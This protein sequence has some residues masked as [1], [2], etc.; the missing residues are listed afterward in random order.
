MTKDD[1][2]DRLLARARDGE[3]AATTAVIEG[4]RPRITRL[5]RHYASRSREEA[6]DLEQEAWVAILESIPQLRLEVGDPRQYLLR[7]G[8]WR[9]LN[10]IN[11]QAARRHEELTDDFD[12]PAPS[13]TSADAHAGHLLE[14][15]FERLTDRQ[16]V[17]LRALLAGHT[18]AETARLLEC[19]T[20]NIAWHMRKIRQVYRALTGQPVERRT[21]A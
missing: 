17:I 8:R 1:P 12:E 5:A 11:E 20:A 3:G 16:A 15:I 9:M 10:F 6:A 13:R 21:G 7:R 4:L 14:R 18:W 2:G 19:S